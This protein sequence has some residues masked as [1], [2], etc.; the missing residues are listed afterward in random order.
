MRGAS[1]AGSTERRPALAGLGTLVVAALL[2]LPLRAAPL[3][4]R[5]VTVFNR[6]PHSINEL[7]ISP[8]TTDQWGEDRLGDRTL[9]AGNSLRVRLGRTRECVFD[10]KVVY[11]DATREEIRGMNLCRLHQL[12]FNAS[13][14]TAPPE[15]GVEHDLTLINHSARP[16][17]QVYISPAEASQWGDDRLGTSSISVADPRKLTWRGDCVVDLRVV[18]ENRAAEERRGVDLCETAV[19]SIE[20]GWTTADTLP[21][22]HR[23]GP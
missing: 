6:S 13:T 21:G 3:A 9:E 5:D 15:T 11:E 10:A 18:F 12:S 22:T 17:Q 20:P 16:I 14:A 1:G 8:A 19:I 23:A 7:Y 2:A 4:E